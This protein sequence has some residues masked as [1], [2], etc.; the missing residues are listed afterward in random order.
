MEAKRAFL[1]DASAARGLTDGF[2]P[3]ARLWAAR[4]RLAL[5]GPALN[6]RFHLRGATRLGQ[7]VTLRGRPKVVNQGT[8]IV[9]DRVRLD[10]TVAT[11]ELVA[12]P[13]GRLEL[14]DNVFINYGSSLVSS[15]CVKVG[16]DCLIGTHVMVMDCDFHRVEDKAWDTAGAPVVLEERVWL[17][18]RS[19]VLKGVTVGHDAVVAA[20]SV[21]IRDVPPRTV[22]AGVPARVVRRF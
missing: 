8:L 15:T 11:L 13:G 17:G 9:G 10:S 3:L 19:M 2:A 1:P 16:N 14:G 21:V 20:G 6:A 22:V 12:L 5:I 4:G 7:R 18:N